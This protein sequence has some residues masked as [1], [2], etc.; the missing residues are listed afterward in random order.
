M[1]AST[2]KAFFELIQII[3][4]IIQRSEILWRGLSIEVLF[5]NKK[6]FTQFSTGLSLGNQ[7]DR[8]LY[9]QK[10]FRHPMGVPASGYQY[11]GQNRKDR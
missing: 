3:Q 4:K 7:V 5:E 8:A 10:R 9:I 2:N 1:A 11:S 6:E